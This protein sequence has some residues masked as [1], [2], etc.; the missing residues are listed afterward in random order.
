MK[1]N[2]I[3]TLLLAASQYIVAQTS[4]YQKLDEWVSVWKE[5]QKTTFGYPANQISPLHSFINGT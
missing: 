2:I 5:A 3:I 4:G 1:R